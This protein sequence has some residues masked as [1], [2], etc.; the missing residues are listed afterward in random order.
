[1]NKADIITDTKDI[2]YKFTL[3][4][5]LSVSF[6]ICSGIPLLSCIIACGILA[7]VY[8]LDYSVPLFP[9]IF[10]FML[11]LCAAKETGLAGAVVAPV[12][13]GLIALLLCKVRPVKNALDKGAFIPAMMVA[14]ALAATVLVTTDY[15]GIGADGK[16]VIDM[17]KNYRSLGFHPN[18]RGI[19]YGTI[20]M[21]IMITY[22]RKFKKAGKTVSALFVALIATYLLN[23]ALVPKGA[24]LTFEVNRPVFEIASFK[25]IDFS[26]LA[27]VKPVILTL[28]YAAA[29]SLAFILAGNDS[30]AGR[31]TIYPL[32]AEVIVPAMFGFTIPGRIEKSGR[33][34]VKGLICAALLAATMLLTKCFS[35]L[36]VPTAA[37]IIIVAAWQALDKS[38]FKGIFARK[39]NIPLFVGTIALSL[40]VNP[41]AGAVAGA[42]VFAAED[43]IT[44]LKKA[45]NNS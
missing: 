1:M 44:G 32:V 37:V 4:A 14:V 35:G 2:A 27:G 7:I 21:V 13:G 3:I 33:E 38:R 40:L 8:K 36:P 11:T 5:A 42:A 25:T 24:V 6:G 23:F 43:A 9:V 10:S 28:I 41:A 26:S 15:F 45:D 17:L 20:T 16:T 29:Q 34:T 30:P 18:W 39:V 12:L 22:P 31:E 19:L